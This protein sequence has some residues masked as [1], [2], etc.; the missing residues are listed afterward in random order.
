MQN[1]SPILARQWW[2][3]FRLSLSLCI[4]LSVSLSPNVPHAQYRKRFRASYNIGSA[5]ALPIIS[6]ALSNTGRTR[7]INAVR[8]LNVIVSRWLNAV[9]ETKIVFFVRDN[10]REKFLTASAA[11]RN[12]S[13][14]IRRACAAV[15]V[16]LSP[17]WKVCVLA[18]RTFLYPA[19]VSLFSFLPDLSPVVTSRHKFDPHAQCT[20]ASGPQAANR[21]ESATSTGPR[22]TWAR[23]HGRTVIMTHL[24][25]VLA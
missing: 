6:I 7:K 16:E 8:R 4:S 12:F 20:S 24:L 25:P 19:V 5:S 9:K 23:L 22:S 18:L 11:R 13:E 3:H 17:A 2:R 14:V 10:S 1:S 21:D 15:G